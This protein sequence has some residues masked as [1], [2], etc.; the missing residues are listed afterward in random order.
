M[1][2]IRKVMPVQSAQ[3]ADNR[4]RVT[5]ATNQLARD[6][7]ILEPAGIQTENFLRVG[8]ILFDHDPKVPVGAP[9]AVG[10]DAE[11]NLSV[12]IQW[13]TPGISPK[14][15]EVRG[16]VKDGTIRS[17]SVGFEPLEMTP[18]EKSQPRGGQHITR[19]DLLELSFVSVP[20][21]TGA[22]VT[23]RSAEDWKCGV[24]RDLPIEDS[25]GWDG[26]AAEAS[27][28]EWAG[29]DDFDP[30]KARKAFLAYNAAKPKER[31][32]YKLPI[33]HVV[34]GRLKVPK[35]AIRAAAS[36]LSQTD[37]PEGVKES[38]Q[39]VIKHYEE[40]AGMGEK[41]RAIVAKHTRALER[42][43][44][45]PTLKRGLCEVAC[46]AY[47]LQQ[48]G[49]A[50]ECAEW[51]AELEG[52]GSAVPGMLGEALVA[53]GKAFIAMANEEATELLED[54]DL[55]LDEEEI[56]VEERSYVAAAQTSRSRAW[57]YGIALARA[58][59]A[60]SASN[61]KKLDEAAGHLDRAMKHH[62]SLGEH[63]ESAAGHM[64][65]ITASQEKARKA[66]ADT[67]DALAA[68]KKEP[69]KAAEH[70]ARA[71]KANKAAVGHLEDAS[72]AA[73][74]LADSH[75][76]AGD[77]HAAIARS[78]KSAQRC[79]RSVVE[80]STPGAEDGDSKDVQ[81]SAGTA[82]S[83]GSEGSRN[84]DFRRRQAE[85]LALAAQ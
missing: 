68:A 38:A 20:A 24:S 83:T 61:E 66:Q 85:L 49:Y 57:R 70:V 81:T 54:K 34:D 63:H 43:P 77:S 73:A 17:V 46:L 47:Q 5:A 22:I 29:G 67:S 76:D 64:D 8:A 32:S 51:E 59:R 42:A 2:M 82:E 33:A 72:D 53:L 11:G 44:K 14:A 50:H 69:E 60:L 78:V 27:V 52:D 45:V 74:N 65:A 58:G 30:S 36:R 79:M 12:E 13:A 41:D 48:L 18:L 4:T 26:P 7:H 16:L 39:A 6:G 1:S 55:E 23:Q 21:D 25:D 40:K 37:I 71:A 31:G 10:L 75:A 19:S 3:I 56:V 80:G 15:D 84:R 9:V 28:F 35:G 62:R